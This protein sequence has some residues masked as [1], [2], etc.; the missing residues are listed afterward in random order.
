MTDP[1]SPLAALRAR[2]EYAC[3][4]IAELP[5]N[6]GR[7]LNARLVIKEVIEAL[8]TPGAGPVDE[9]CV[10]GYVR[11]SLGC[12]S[13]CAAP[14]LVRDADGL[15]FLATPAPVAVEGWNEA[16]RTINYT[17]WM[18]GNGGSEPPEDWKAGYI[19]AI[20]TPQAAA[21]VSDA[22]VE[23]AQAAMDK[24][25]GDYPGGDSHGAERRAMFAALTAALRPSD[26][27]GEVDRG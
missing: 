17:L 8:A 19:A 18:D 12:D 13:V 16:I 2:L 6:A 4:L 11:D 1:T 15:H 25:L 24:S 21:Q 7:S 26:R 20:T 22:M 14:Q 27:A 3:T 9:T 5:V 10:C 23:R